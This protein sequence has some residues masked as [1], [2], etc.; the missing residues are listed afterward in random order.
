[1]DSIIAF[2]LL[3]SAWFTPT[4]T[5]SAVPDIFQPGATSTAMVAR[6]IDGDTIDVLLAGTKYRV[7]YI[8]IDTPE[9]YADAVP[10]CFSI[11]ASARNRELVEGRLVTL[12]ADQEDRDKY[13][14]LLRYVYVDDIF[15]NDVLVREGFATTLPIRP[16]ITY[17]TEFRVRELEALQA[18]RGL[19]SACPQ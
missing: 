14:R 11:E 1:M 2:I 10:E 13:D 6:V 3:I 12:V 7:R 16:N 4:A 18:K 5:P 15:V 8:G 9:P 19:W 17:A